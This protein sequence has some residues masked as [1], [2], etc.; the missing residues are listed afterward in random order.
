MFMVHDSR[1]RRQRA[2]PP[3]SG[4]IAGV[5]AGRSDQQA[6]GAQVER[7]TGRVRIRVIAWKPVVGSQSQALR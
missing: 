1:T 6:Q 2:N 7:R 3:D 5:A 4:T